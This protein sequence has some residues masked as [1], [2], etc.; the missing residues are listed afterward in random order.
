MVDIVRDR[1]TL[2]YNRGVLRSPWYSLH[3]LSLYCLHSTISILRSPKILIQP[4]FYTVLI[5]TV[6][7]SSRSP[8]Y[9][10]LETIA[11]LP[12]SYELCHTTF[13][14]LPLPFV[15]PRTVRK[16]KQSAGTMNQQGEPFG[17]SRKDASI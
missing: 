12:S 2:C 15:P 10:R 9:N 13:A 17:E 8:C 1:S 11:M 7:M 14:I 6:I 5:Y 3:L 4:T 16:W